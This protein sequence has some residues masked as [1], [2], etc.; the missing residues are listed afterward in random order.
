MYTTTEA[1]VLQLHPYKDKSAVVKLYSAQMGLISCWVSSVHSKKS[2]TKVA[3]LQPLSII[4][5]E[6]SYRENNNLPQLKEV[7]L[8]QHNPNIALGIEKS[9]IAIFL[10]ELLL[11]CI[12]ESSQDLPLYNFVR[13]SISLLD[14]THEKCSNFHLLFLVRLCDH[15]GFL[16]EGNFT[17]AAPYFNM[18]ESHYQGAIPL[19]PNFLQPIESE[20]LSKL[21]S[22]PMEEF[23]TVT[24]PSASRKKL[25]HGLLQYYG[26][27]LGMLPLKSHL[28]LEEVL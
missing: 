1:I 3:V 25:L 27:H 23:S 11:R 9:S 17:K 14:N 24:I 21:S 18:E 10:A 16:P 12:K 19:H 22:L 2:K 4:N 15:F 6:V 28:V 7:N 20:W 8:A 5:A 13:D 26:I